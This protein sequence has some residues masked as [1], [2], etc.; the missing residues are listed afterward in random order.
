MH[1]EIP[2]TMFVPSGERNPLDTLGLAF[3]QPLIQLMAWARITEQPILQKTKFRNFCFTEK[4]KDSKHTHIKQTNILEENKQLWITVRRLRQPVL[5]G[6]TANE[7]FADVRVKRNHVVQYYHNVSFRATHY[8]RFIFRNAKSHC[9]LIWQVTCFRL[10]LETEKG[11]FHERCHYAQ[12]SRP[13][14]YIWRYQL[15]TALLH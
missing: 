8:K 13:Q 6:K 2:Q 1:F 11:R 5:Q 10:I 14:S 7:V 3:S 12:R 9:S 15:I 4:C